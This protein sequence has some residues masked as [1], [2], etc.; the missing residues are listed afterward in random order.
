[1]K[2]LSP[3]RLS[4]TIC[5]L[6][7]LT[8]LTASA[9]T[10]TTLALFNGTNGSAPGDIA[11]AQ[12]FDGNFYGTTVYGGPS[13]AGVVFNVSPSGTLH[14]LYNFCGNCAGG[15]FAEGPQVLAANGDFYGT[16]ENGGPLAAAAGTAF[17]LA[18]HGAV[19]DFYSFCS[20]PNCDDG[21]QPSSGLIQANDGNFYGTAPGGGVNGNATG[22]IFK[23]ATNGTFTLLYSFC[24]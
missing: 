11:L 22:T 14:P 3:F 15:Y 23:I 16:T 1:M 17:K 20:Q 9:Q 8:L 13:N 21:S 10:F 5:L 6:Y 24:S 18:A 12:G 2:K 4:L 7:A 19:T